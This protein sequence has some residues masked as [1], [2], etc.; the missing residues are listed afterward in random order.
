VKADPSRLVWVHAQSEKDHAVHEKFARAGAWVEFDGIAPDS[1]D[2]HRECVEFMAGKGL[3]GRTL[4]SQDAGW[5]HVAE[6]GG[7]AYR[8][9]T[10][11]Y[12]DFLPRLDPAWARQLMSTNPA[13]AF[14]A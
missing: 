2:W 5:Y 8:G 3:L 13:Q 11:I 9:Y 12:T 1:A 7:G 4:I 6:P 14:G 10:Y